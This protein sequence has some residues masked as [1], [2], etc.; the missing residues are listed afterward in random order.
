MFRVCLI[1]PPF[2]ALHAPSFAL[3]QLSELIGSRHEKDRLQ[4]SV[5]YLNIDFAE[6]LGADL[7]TF[8]AVSMDAL[9]C[10]LGDWFFRPAAFPEAEDNAEDYYW[11]FRHHMR[12]PGGQSWWD[13]ILEKR[14]EV[15][16]ILDE[17]IDRH[18]LDTA[19]LVGCTSMFMQNAAGFALARKL[20][21][22]NPNI[23]TVM[24]GA[25]CEA[26]MG[27]Q[28]ARHVESL[29]YIFSGPALINF[30]Q[31][32]ECCINGDAAARDRIDG[33][34][35]NPR[36]A[37]AAQAAAGPF[38]I[39]NPNGGSNP[40]SKPVVGKDCDIDQPFQLDY[41]GFLNSLRGS[42]GDKITPILFFETSRG[43]WWGE[44]AHC[45]FC[46]LNGQSMNYRSM[47]PDLAVKQL[48]TLFR[49]SDRV[50]EL[51][52]VDNILPRKYLTDV[53]PHLDTP[54]NMHIFYEVKADL[55]EEEIRT[56]ARA[57]V[58][59][60]QPGI[61]AL[62]TSTLKLMKKGTTAHQN[63]EFLKHCARYGIEPAWNLLIGF[64][65]EQEDVYRKY[66][67]DLP[68]L[69]HLPPPYGVF[70]IR[71]DR[72]SPYYVKAEEYGLSLKPLDFYELVYPFPE[73]SLAQMA[74]FFS[75]DNVLAP[76]ALSAATWVKK[77]RERVQVW[78]DL[79]FGESAG[80]RPVLRFENENSSV[81]VD[82]RSGRLLRYD[83]GASGRDLLD[84]MPRPRKADELE[85]D[86]SADTLRAVREK[87][88][89]FEENG[90][91]VSLLLSGPRPA[92][93]ATL[94]Y[95]KEQ[96]VN[97][98]ILARPAL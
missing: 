13:T 83:I 86:F 32:V 66:V 57:R 71:F 76:Y 9:H 81:V 48:K 19:D 33:V 16:R 95:W 34:I 69:V 70:P 97:D 22:R 56:L 43:C 29:D 4:S 75:D 67:S 61:E 64:P 35:T 93:H 17:L 94:P 63:V 65:G 80:A 98:A 87:G 3:T 30:P 77:L 88:L 74:Y 92:E 15:D 40:S 27:E 2:A 8:I 37:M 85:R 55:S 54:P 10:G 50:E 31:F 5:H 51:Q 53:L 36:R 1:N 68:L 89:V 39:L 82:S 91:V 20:K 62:N 18:H 26:P 7:Y 90:R 49:Y 28:I 45:T 79:W 72:Y 6:Y 23:I 12:A 52:A 11:R 78:R 38:T 59:K 73:E 84:S 44:K 41:E 58:T 60:I 96:P 14:A 25:N 21:Q 42:F 47:S 24:G 46:G